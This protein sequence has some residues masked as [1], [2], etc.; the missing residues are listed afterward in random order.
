M[1]TAVG[2]LALLAYEFVITFDDEYNLIWT[3]VTKLYTLSG[4]IPNPDL[5]RSV[6]GYPVNRDIH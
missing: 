1:H 4:I 5:F 2:A 3:C 6:W